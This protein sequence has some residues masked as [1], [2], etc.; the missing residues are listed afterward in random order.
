MSCLSLSLYLFLCACVCVCICEHITGYSYSNNFIVGLTN[1]KPSVSVTLWNYKLCGRYP[2]AV[3]SGA[4]V[5]LTCARDL[6]P[7]RFVIVQFQITTYM[8]FCE[9]EVFAYGQE[10]VNVHRLSKFLLFA[11]IY[12]DFCQTIVCCLI[13]SMVIS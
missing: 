5:S 12:F 4:T 8:Y 2:G 13:L 10:L 6:P 9:L 7:F 11:L 1:N 3:G